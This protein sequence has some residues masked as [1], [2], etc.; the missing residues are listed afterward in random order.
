MYLIIT[1][2]FMK[3]LEHANVVFDVL[4]LNYI[5]ALNNKKCF[6]SVWSTYDVQEVQWSY[7]TQVPA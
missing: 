4:K 7:K 6:L 1:S 2:K 5:A 3:L